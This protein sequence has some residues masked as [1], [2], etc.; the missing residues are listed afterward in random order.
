[1]SK[2]MPQSKVRYSEQRCSHLHSTAVALFILFLV[3]FLPTTA[4]AQSVNCGEFVSLE[5][6]AIM[7]T[8]S[9]GD[10]TSNLQCAFDEASRLDARLIKL[11]RGTFTLRDKVTARDFRGTLEGVSRTATI[12]NLD[13]GRFTCATT[14]DIA[15]T[16]PDVGAGLEFILGNP[17]V[18][19]LTMQ[20]VNPCRNPGAFSYI[21]FT[22]N[23]S[24]CSQRTFL[25]FVDRVNFIGRSS[26][27]AVEN[28]NFRAGVAALR[29]PGCEGQSPTGTLKL[30][31]NEFVDLDF[32][33]L[34]SMVAGAEVDINF[35]TFTDTSN[36]IT[37]VD[38]NQNTS[39]VENTFEMGGQGF[40]V[41]G[42]TLQ[43]A[44]VVGTSSTGAPDTNRTV[45]HSNRFLDRG[46]ADTSGHVL[47][48]ALESRPN[49]A[50][51]ISNNIFELGDTP[52]SGAI[53]VSDTDNGVIQRNTFRGSGFTGIQ[54][55]RE[56]F[57]TQVE[58]WSVVGNSF[59]GLDS[60]EGDIIFSSGTRNNIVGPD[61][62]ATVNSSN[63][64][65]IL[66]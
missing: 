16:L 15:E 33:L 9:G 28:S 26:R 12:L 20:S 41:D 19:F 17:S 63:T 39:I 5:G 53:L 42:E 54:I 52:F 47:I 64:N 45:I 55:E 44:V 43:L 65:T 14:G 66:N 23:G 36:P 30:N 21:L 60:S 40:L 48:N 24:N 25:G 61:Q 62:A 50:V 49:H 51:V 6:V 46:T 18:R 56:E 29:A 11:D 27:L 7:L 35:N 32:G 34:S 3:Q 57:S 22:S 4:W 58:G 2:C 10:D 8:P 31:R 1:M 13:D 38:A 59:A 37:I